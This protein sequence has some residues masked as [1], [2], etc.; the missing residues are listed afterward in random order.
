MCNSAGLETSEEEQLPEA[1]DTQAPE[2]TETES[3]TPA[4]SEAIVES[5]SASQDTEAAEI[6]QSAHEDF[7]EEAVVTRE[8]VDVEALSKIEEELRKLRQ[9]FQNKLMY[10]QSKETM[11]NNMHKELQKHKE[12]LY[13]MLI[14]PVLSEI[15]GLRESILR[16]ASAH[17]AKPEGE[18]NV[19][20]D[21]F[22]CYADEAM[23]ILENNGVEC[24]K[25]K[26]GEK[27]IPLRQRIVEKIPTDDP[28]QHSLIAESRGYGYEIAGRIISP[29]KVSVYIH[30]PN[31]VPAVQNGSN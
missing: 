29:E 2:I 3:E 30:D 9:D 19:P 22:S 7:E 16:V 20:L 8:Q 26:T 24:Y 14:R 5:I 10:D 23:D 4:E 31:S 1:L 21:S 28:S 15:I 6:A 11:F 18:R 27:Y 12:D 13:A 25:S 17:E